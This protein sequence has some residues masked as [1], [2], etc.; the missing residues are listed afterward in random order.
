M[1]HVGNRETKPLTEVEGFRSTYWYIEMVSREVP[2]P[3]H[4][5]TA[6]CS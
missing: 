5:P 6:S 2:L 1:A 3:Q 4:N